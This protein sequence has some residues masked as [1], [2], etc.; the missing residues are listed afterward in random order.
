MGATPLYLVII[1][2]RANAYSHASVTLRLSGTVQD[3]M[4]VAELRNTVE[5]TYNQIWNSFETL[6]ACPH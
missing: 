5:H 6:G 2:A 4:L 1:L 3:V